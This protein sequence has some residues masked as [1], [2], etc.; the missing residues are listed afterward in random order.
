MECTR[1]GTDTTRPPL[2]YDTISSPDPLRDFEDTN[3]VIWLCDQCIEDFKEFLE[4]D[5][6][7]ELSGDV[8]RIGVG[9]VDGA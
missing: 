2:S 6:T 7:L 1:C 5:T 9:D 3:G 4:G 8:E